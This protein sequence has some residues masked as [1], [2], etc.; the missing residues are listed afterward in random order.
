CGVAGEVHPRRP[1]AGRAVLGADP[2]GPGR[3]RPARLLA[4]GRAP[5]AGGPVGPPNLARS[6]SVRA[7]SVDFVR[8]FTSAYAVP[9]PTHLRL[10]VHRPVTPSVNRPKKEPAPP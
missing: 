3:R 2:G 4:G 6:A 9:V 7:L 8:S 1:G 10:P 5:A